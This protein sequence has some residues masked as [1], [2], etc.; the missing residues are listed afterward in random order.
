MARQAFN[1]I[2]DRPYDWLAARLSKGNVET[3]RYARGNVEE[4]FAALVTNN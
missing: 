3:L 1:A 2:F 4:Q